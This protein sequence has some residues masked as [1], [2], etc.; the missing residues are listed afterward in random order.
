MMTKSSLRPV[1]L[2]MLSDRGTDCVFF[3]PS[4]VSSYAQ[5]R[6]SAHGE[7]RGLLE[8]KQRELVA[9]SGRFR[10]GARTEATSINS[11]PTTA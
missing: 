7:A 10:A 5:D 9:E 4:G 11:Q 3:M 8:G 1:T 2:V 6:S